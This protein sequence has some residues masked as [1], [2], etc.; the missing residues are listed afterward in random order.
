[1][2]WPGR[3]DVNLS[4]NSASC[5]SATAA[6]GMPCVSGN[7]LAGIDI[8]ADRSLDLDLRPIA[9]TGTVHLNDGNFATSY[10][11]GYISFA[12]VAIPGDFGSTI[13]VVP[14]STPF[15]YAINVLPGRYVARYTASFDA[16]TGAMPPAVPCVVEVL[17]GCDA[18]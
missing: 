10:D 14:G 8:A 4:V 11:P 15:S 3:Y 17:A 6:P 7:I 2:L 12:S 1:E 16:C 5:A 9:L 13:P 18:P